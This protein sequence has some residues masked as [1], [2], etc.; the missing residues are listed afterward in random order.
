M[1]KGVQAGAAISAGIVFA[2]QLA[3]QT[4]WEADKAPTTELPQL[5]GQG[6]PVRIG[7]G[8]TKVLTFAHITDPHL[9]V[10]DETAENFAAFEKYMKS[11]MAWHTEKQYGQVMAELA[12]RNIAQ[13]VLTGDVVDYASDENLRMFSALFFSSATRISYCLGNH[14]YATLK[15]DEKARGEWRLRDSIEEVTTHWN[16]KAG[17]FGPGYYRLQWAAHDIILLDNGPGDFDEKQLE[18]L[19]GELAKTSARTAVLAFHIPL[20]T[21]YLAEQLKGETRGMLVPNSSG[22]FELLRQHKNIGALL[23]GH[24]H[25]NF[26]TKVAGIPQYVTSAMFHSGFRLVECYA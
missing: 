11:R 6:T 16:L 22:I 23:T 14:D 13:A 26:E 9:Y 3:A 17:P 1:E 21:D 19:D 7:D 10:I 5:V 15:V 12:R 8:A 25:R 20:Y 18:W 2:R 24:L 4:P